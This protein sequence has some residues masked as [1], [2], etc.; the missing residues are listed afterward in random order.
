MSEHTPTPWY[1]DPDLPQAVTDDHNPR[2]I[3]TCQQSIDAAFIVRACNAH[4]ALVEACKKVLRDHR[5]QLPSE[6]A[7]LYCGGCECPQCQMIR[8]AIAKAEEVTA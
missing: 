7:D 5:A 2:V 3:A 8:A 6:A 1:K 4:D